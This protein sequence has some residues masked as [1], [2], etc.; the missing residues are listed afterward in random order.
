M[1]LCGRCIKMNILIL[2]CGTRNKL[3][4]FFRE[5]KEYE[6]VIVTDC[7]EQA[8]ALYVAD[9]YYIVPRMNQ[10]GYFDTLLQICKDE[11]IDVMLPLQEEEL[12]LIAKNREIFEKVGVTPI[13]SEY[14]KVVLCKDKYA[15]NS[16]LN[17]KGIP[18]IPTM[19][20]KDYLENN[21]EVK[22][23][24]VKPRCGA[25]SINT[26]A[27][28]SRRLLEALM[29]EAEEELIVQPKITGKEFGVDVYVD[30]I[31]GEIITGFCKEKLRMRA[32]E[33]EK[34]VS[35]INKEVEELA[36]HAVSALG[37]RGPLD[38]D[39]MEQDG[40]YYVLEINP[41]FGGG[42]PHAYACGISFPDYIAKNGKG[43]EN[44]VRRNDYPENILVMKYSEILVK[45]D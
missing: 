44:A 16:W 45:E 6:R 38:V 29:E 24:F 5:S 30:M 36:T 25:G 1:E 15:L 42:Y 23:I 17:E 13:V 11:D 21:E 14:E 28:H 39:V 34:S 33:T 31:S 40:K 8:P 4:S 41:R 37:L 12:L 26:F 3:V 32:G 18:A 7:S 9:K 22:D 20:A 35:V 19:L 27:V 43:M 2:S 10:D